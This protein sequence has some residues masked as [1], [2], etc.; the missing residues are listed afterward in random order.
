MFVLDCG[1]GLRYRW[2]RSC[3]L[4]F[5]KMNE[6]IGRLEPTSSNLM[7]NYSKQ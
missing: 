2:K 5:S 4:E 7:H 1:T 6:A 3:I